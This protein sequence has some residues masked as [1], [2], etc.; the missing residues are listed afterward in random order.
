M[1]KCKCCKCCKNIVSHGYQPKASPAKPDFVQP[2][3]PLAV[4][5]NSDFKKIYPWF[6]SAVIY[7]V[8]GVL[9]GVVERLYA[10]SYFS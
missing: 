5:S 1:C 10:T 3:P 4:L 2:P 6:Y 8:L 9:V 7:S